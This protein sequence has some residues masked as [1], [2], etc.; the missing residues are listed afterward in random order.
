MRPARTRGEQRPVAVDQSF[1]SVAQ[2]VAQEILNLK[3]VSSN[4]TGPTMERQAD[5]VTAA[6]SKTVEV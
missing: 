2:L 6:V 5:M 4:L 3:V 1:G